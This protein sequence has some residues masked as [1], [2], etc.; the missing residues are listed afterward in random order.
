MKK[1]VPLLV[2]VLFLFGCGSSPEK[3]ITVS[4]EICPPE[5]S[6]HVLYIPFPRDIEVDG[7]LSDWEG[8]PVT[9]VD[10]GPKL[11][12]GGQFSFSTAAKGNTLYVYMLA[13]DPNIVTG[14]HGSDYWNEDSME[15]YFNFSDDVFATGYGEGI[16]QINI[17]PGD[18]GNSDPKELTLTGSN[19]SQA[20]VSGYV[21]ETEEGWGFEIAV[22]MPFEVGHGK[23]IGF[24]AHLNGASLK[25]RN[26]K[27]IWS[28][29]DVK[30]NSYENPRLFGQALFFEIGATT[31]PPYSMFEEEIPEA[32]I[33]VNQAGYYLNRNK[34]AVLP[35]EEEKRSYS[36]TLI[37]EE[38]GK[39][40]FNGK[41]AAAYLDKA[42][43]DY[44][45]EIDFSDFKE[46]GR[47]Y[48]L[49]PALKVKSVPFTIGDDIYGNLPVDSM[50]Y[51]Y[52][53]RSGT[54][55]EA[56]YAGG[57]EYARGPGHLSDSEVTGYKGRDGQGQSWVGTEY[58]LDASK[59]WYD[60][61]D[62]GKYVVNG[63]IAAWT[64]MNTADILPGYY[65]DGSLSLPEGNN[66]APDVLDE[67]RWEM[68]FLLG[69]QV[70]EGYKKAGM[71]HHKLHDVHWGPIPWLP[72]AE[73]DND[74]DHSNPNGGRYL[75][76]PSTA[77]TL[78]LA[79]TAAQSSRLWADYDAD[80]SSR[81]LDAAEKAW[82]A[83]RENPLFLYG[84]I[85]G[86]GGGNYDD[87]NVDDEYFWAAAELYA[88]T[89]KEVYLDFL[90]ASV[91]W[92][93]TREFSKTGP[94]SI[95]WG[96]TAA[97]GRITLAMVETDLSDEDRKHF[98]DQI[99]AQADYYLSLTE[100]GYG[101]SLPVTGYVWGSNSNMLNNSILIA[102]AHRFTGDDKYMTGLIS[103]LDYLMG[104]NGLN[105]S[106][107]S[108]YGTNS[109]SHPLHHFWADQPHKGFPKV[110]AGVVAGGPNENPSDPTAQAP[111]VTSRGISK[112]YVDSSKSWSTNEVAIN[113]NSPLA[114]I[115]AYV[116][117]EIGK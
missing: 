67:A 101:P 54:P 6:G 113:W 83:S 70:P 57:E 97:L 37:D 71:V 9:V 4:Y 15:V 64:L 25:D 94:S 41:T 59:G 78:N 39:S 74:N 77:A 2:M 98:R 104:M 69:M 93:Q 58:T 95:W 21:F 88:A 30:D 24:Q 52:R 63:G 105:F 91:Y 46:P 86:E 38:S 1:M 49:I 117:S 89:G 40:V 60:A 29:N 116:D 66:G 72:P 34:K 56:Q 62:V 22:T 111:E 99:I 36:W 53:N 87:S 14:K 42:S 43:G 35:L 23:E 90:K 80:F 3:E 85:P 8:L 45:N 5:I 51:F 110:P 19:S 114:W 75:M 44:I 79:A 68:E 27:L 13:V 81:C 115:S 100:E 108:G 55:I 102:C 12:P 17:N 10:R 92:N 16:Y 76:P 33:A 65:G 106:F 109:L 32:F 112:R 20:D 47:Y 18:R 82:K 48:L 107:V 11:I 73:Y 84:N 31:L 26:Q 7:D 28:R 50:A 103:A 96:G 61:G